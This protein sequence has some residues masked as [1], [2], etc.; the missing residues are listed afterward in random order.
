VSQVK[1]KAL[2][3]G[4]HKDRIEAITKLSGIMKIFH[5]MKNSS[6]EIIM[7]SQLESTAALYSEMLE[8]FYLD[9][10]FYADPRT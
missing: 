10:V 6:G 1:V 5:G 7:K 3:P 8:S 2:R 4:P 9:K